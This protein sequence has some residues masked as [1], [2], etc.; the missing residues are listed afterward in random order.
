M[1]PGLR[2]YVL[3]RVGFAV[4]MLVGVSIILFTIMRLAPGGPEAV[5]IGGEFSP[6]AAEQIRRRLGLDRPIALQY[7]GWAGA[8]VRGDL[9]RSFKTGDPVAAL[10]F[11]RLGPT[12]QLTSGALALA[13]VVA[14]PLGVLAAVRR[15][16]IWDTLGSAVALFGVSFPS[17]WLGIM[18]ILIFS[19]A[20]P[21]LPP[22]GLAEYGRESEPLSRL[23]H[24]IL[25]TLTLGLIQM[26]ALM[27]FTRSS[28]LESL[29]QDYVRTARAKGL[30][31]GRVV[32]RHALRNALIP[33]VT[34]VGLS[35]PALV[36]GAVLTETVFAWPGI[37]RLAVG[38]AFERDYP[39]IM[40]VNLI[41]A[42]VVITGN[43]VTDLAYCAIDPRISYR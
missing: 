14:V 43:L 30:G 6:E 7:L 37:G 34:V 35:L 26:A 12:L 16:T 17:F 10:I 36:G 4:L 39:V 8:A 5:L 25:P 24:A 41:V 28:L 22:S 15:G 2:T 9:G 18:L 23:R 13:L 31:D 32:W 21:I 29:R 11:D 42:A 1:E 33:V 40:G 27:R 3:K 38:A 20:L 19:E